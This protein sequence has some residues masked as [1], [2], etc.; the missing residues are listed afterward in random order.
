MAN[1]IRRSAW[2]AWFLLSASTAASPHDAGVVEVALGFFI[3]PDA[4]GI[5]ERLDAV[6]P[7]PVTPADRDRALAML[8]AEGE[9]AHLDAARRSKVASTRRVLAVHGRET[10]YVVKVIDV[11]QAAVAL[12]ARAVVLISEPALDLLDSEEL[13]ALVAH[14]VGHEFFWNEYAAARRHDDAPELR[15]LELVCDGL[16]IVTLR[17]AGMDPKRLTSALEK[18]LRYNRDRFGAASNEHHYPSATERRAFAKRLVEGLGRSS[19]DGSRSLWQSSQP[20]PHQRED[21]Q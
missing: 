21:H 6:R 19:P 7:S 2:A 8:P 13:Q 14:E 16:A 11:P 9:V 4:T 12:H 1:R 17:R 5:V 18:V 10:V 15:R 20:P 3:A